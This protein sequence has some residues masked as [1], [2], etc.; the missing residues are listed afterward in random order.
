MA[1]D[2]Y[3]SISEISLCTQDFLHSFFRSR[4]KECFQKKKTVWEG[5]GR[6]YSEMAF[7]VSLSDTLW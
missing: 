6:G 4:G 1:S 7:Q 3:W 2:T 5:L